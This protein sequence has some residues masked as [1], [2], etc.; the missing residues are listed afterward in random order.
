MRK[1]FVNDQR[2]HMVILCICYLTAHLITACSTSPLYPYSQGADSALFALVGRGITEGKIMYTDFFDHKGPFIFFF[3]ALGYFIG[4]RTGIFLLQGV[5]GCIS[6]IFIYKAYS[7]LHSSDHKMYAWDYLFLFVCGYIVCFHTFENGNLTEEYSQ[8]F[9]SCSL[10]LFAKY[11]TQTK[12]HPEHPPIYAFVYGIC[13]AFL[14]F[15]R[16]NNAVSVCAGILALFLYLL[17]TKQYKNLLL[18]LLFGVLGLSAVVVPVCVYFWY[19]S[20]LEDMIFAAFIYNFRIFG[21]ASQYNLLTNPNVYFALYLPIIICFILQIT[22]IIKSRAITF[23]DFLLAIILLCNTINLW[24]ANRYAHYFALFVPVY[25]VFLSQYFVIDF[26]KAVTYIVILCTLCNARFLMRNLLWGI[27]INFISK[28]EQI[29]SSAVQQGISQIPENERKSIIGYEI[30]VS[31]YVHGDILP[32][33]KYYTW[34]ENWGNV[35][36]EVLADFMDFLIVDQPLWVL[37]T[38]EEDNSVLLEILSNQYSLQF[39]NQALSAYRLLEE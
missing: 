30:P 3:N 34:Q 4:G 12:V 32:C 19:H 10:Y 21:G 35:N 15:M 37:T 5:F 38:P 16:L 23:I 1:N 9:I 8:P 27:N 17:Y 2:F 31:Y 14:A 7:I 39:K 33:Y 29:T 6:L 22:K 20:A 18:N 13:L 24:I 28:S 25:I 36:P 26:K 11:A